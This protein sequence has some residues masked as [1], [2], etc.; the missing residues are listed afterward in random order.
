MSSLQSPSTLLK[1]AIA[2]DESLL[3]DC[4][5]Q[6]FSN[7]QTLMDAFIVRTL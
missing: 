1:E 7:L 6:T 4:L 5:F 2:G 3:K